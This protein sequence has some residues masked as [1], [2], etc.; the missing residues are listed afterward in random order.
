[1]NL[2]A[3]LGRTAPSMLMAGSHQ[4]CSTDAGLAYGFRELGW[5]VAEVSVYDGL[6]LSEILALRTAARLIAPLSKRS[7]NTAILNEAKRL[8]PDILFAV[9][10]TFIAKSTVI[11]LRE[12]GIPTVIF[13][14]DYRL[15]Y[16]GLDEGM[17]DACDLIITSKSFQVPYL[18]ERIGEGR[19]AFVH[20]GYVP[21]VHRRRTPEGATPEYL[22]DVSYVG[23]ASPSKVEWLVDVAR[24]IGDRRFIVVGH[25]WMEA[26]KGTPLEPFILGHGLAGDHFAR[27][28]EHSRI[29][30]A[31]HMGKG[32]NQ[33]WE[34]LVSTRTFEIPASGGFMLH[35]DNPEVRSLFKV[36]EEID[37]FSSTDELNAKID[38]YLKHPDERIAMVE[39]ASRRCVPAYSL[40]ARAREI[41]DLLAAR[42]IRGVPGS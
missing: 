32:G 10:G 29:N 17:L 6:I 38:Y 24:H 12:W 31:L 26:A 2:F 13:Y 8:R 40:G 16:P 36:P 42:G 9:K 3:G 35:I 30:I 37:V 34:D 5:D 14:P 22:W 15:Q 4:S 18:A 20:H 33:G 7:F 1:M 23:N 25:R 39:R 19:V 27:V 28:I 11:M 41:T 21:A